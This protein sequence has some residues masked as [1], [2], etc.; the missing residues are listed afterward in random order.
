MRKSLLETFDEIWLLD[1]HGNSK[2]KE[3]SPDGGRDQNVFDIQQGVAIGIF[4]K[5]G[6]SD[7]ELASVRHAD[8]WGD[9]GDL[10]S[11]KYA[12]LA[13]NDVVTT[14]W[15]ELAPRSPD[16]FFAPRDYE[17]AA[18]YD[19]GWSLPSIF[20][21]NGDPA[22]GIVTTHDQFAVSWDAEDAIGKIE[23]FLATETEEDA[24][25]LWRLCKQDQ[26]DYGRAKAELANQAWRTKLERLLYRPFDIRTTVFDRNVA[27]HRRERVMHHM[28]T[29]PN[30]G[31]S[32]TRSIEIA[33]GWEHVFVA[34]EL[35]QHHT[36]S[37]KEVN[38]LFP[39]C[40][41][42]ADD[43]ALNLGVADRSPNLAHE[44]VES[45]AERTA[46]QFVPDGQGDLES[47]FG[48]EDIFHYIYAVLHSPQ[49]R[50]KYADFLRSDFPRIPVPTGHALFAQLAQIGAQLTSLHLMT[51]HGDDM[52]PFTI[53]G[54]REV[55]SV[56]YGEPSDDTPGRVWINRDQHFAG[57]SPQTWQFTIGGYQPAKKW[58]QDRKG[59]VLDF[60]DIQTYQRICAALA[61]TPRIMQEID[62]IIESHGDWPFRAHLVHGRESDLSQAE[63]TSEPQRITKALDTLAEFEFE[64]RENAWR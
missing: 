39:L 29:G 11:G 20:C 49:Y 2:R 50:R 64:D 22:P 57:V 42:P 40:L 7:D 30:L 5:H 21:L 55:T 62:D 60:E 47:T 33:S 28:L 18:E 35:T 54:S 51:T 13:E 53:D 1:L 9:R 52:P 15:S 48:P 59:R 32:T 4:V 14:D 34:D 45:V 46:M 58:L 27:V 6:G 17:L 43:D 31:L 12:W 38:Y 23:R 16:Y 44:F 8:L 63:D 56:R 26:W 36:V 19:G 24:R 10:K 37:N 3:R 25:Q 41:Y 61:E